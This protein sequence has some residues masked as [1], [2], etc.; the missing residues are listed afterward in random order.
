MEF[1]VSRH[2]RQKYEFDQGLFATNGNVIFSNFRA[3]REFA[4]KINARRDLSQYPQQ[5][6]RAGQLNAMGL[7]TRSFM[8]W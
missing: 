6:I 7:S 2:A 3:A 1:H 5:A 4:Q 8:W